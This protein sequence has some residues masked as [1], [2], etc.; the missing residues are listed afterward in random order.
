MLLEFMNGSNS[1]NLYRS[2]RSKF[3]ELQETKKILTKA[4]ER[5]TI[6]TKREESRE[7]RDNNRMQIGSA[8]Y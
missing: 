5:T 8:V 2:S 3:V 6:E 4:I 7:E 1:S